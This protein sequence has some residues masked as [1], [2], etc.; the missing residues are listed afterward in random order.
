MLKTTEESSINP[1]IFRNTLAGSSLLGEQ[2]I[3]QDLVSL[4]ETNRQY[5][6]EKKQHRSGDDD[7]GLPSEYA[8]EK[9]WQD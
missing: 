9:G 4:A 5:P 1:S 6:P 2:H 3:I 8:A 7:R